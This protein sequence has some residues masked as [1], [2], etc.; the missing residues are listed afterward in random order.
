[1]RGLKTA[2]ESPNLPDERGRKLAELIRRQGP[3]SRWELH[4]KLQLHP[5]LVGASVGELIRLGIVREEAV[6]VGAPGRPRIPLAIDPAS[7]HILGV[8]LA[9][10]QV[11]IGR[12]S[13]TGEPLEEEREYHYPPAKLIEKTAGLLQERLSESTFAIGLATPG[14][15]DP[16]NNVLLLS[17]ITSVRQRT[18]SLAPLADAAGATPLFIDNDM[19]ALAQRWRLTNGAGASPVLLIGVDDARLGA[20]LLAGGQP[21]PGCMIA[22]NELGHMR[23]PIDTDRCFCGGEGCLECIVSTPQLHRFG[24]PAALTLADALVG[25]STGEVA[26]GRILDC[27]ATGI[28]NAIHLV[29]P[30]KVVVVSPFAGHGFF[31]DALSRRITQRLM[32]PLSR[33]VEVEFWAQASVQSA[34]N[35]AWLALAALYSPSL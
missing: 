15:L 1:M 18:H 20:S 23:L 35:A 8:G 26:A 25:P 5:N 12:V 11:R 9:P 2:S 28:V 27:L 21:V 19:H 4:Q 34:Q 14:F 7:R 13:L 3:L 6:P 30:A 24:A 22:A 17:S 16:Q 29:L 33:R 32:A 31:R 10:H